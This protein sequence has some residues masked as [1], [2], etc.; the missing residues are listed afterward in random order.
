MIYIC[1]KCNSIL[2]SDEDLI[3]KCYKCNSTEINYDNNVSVIYHQY[4]AELSIDAK[5]SLSNFH[6]CEENNYNSLKVKIE[7]EESKILSSY[8]ILRQEFVNYTNFYFYFVDEE[9]YIQIDDDHEDECFTCDDCKTEISESPFGYIKL[10]EKKRLLFLSFVGELIEILYERKYGCVENSKFP[11]KI[12]IR[13][14][15]V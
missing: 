14:T 5:L 8:F 6:D 4:F 12:V 2:D 13:S 7:N 15:D 9:L 11:E 10:N 3:T 1:K